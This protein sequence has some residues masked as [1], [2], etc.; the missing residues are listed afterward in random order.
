MTGQYCFHPHSSAKSLRNE[1]VDVFCTY[2]DRNYWAQGLAMWRSLRRVEPRAIL[3]VLCLDDEVFEL[4]TDAAYPGLHAICLSDV[5][6]WEPDLLRVKSQRSRIEYYF[7]LSPILPSYVLE[8]DERAASVTYLDADLW[9]FTSP[10]ALFQELGDASVGVI[11]HRFAAELDEKNKFGK[12]NV[13]WVTFRRDSR[14]NAV[15]GDWR[16]RCLEWCFD[17]SEDGRFADQGYLN[18]WP[19][20]FGGVKVLE[21]PG[22]NVAPWN[23]GRYMLGDKSGSPTVDG[24]PVIFFHF[25]GL[26]RTGR[27]VWWPRLRA[28]HVRTTAMVYRLLSQP[29]LR[30]LGW[31]ADH[32]EQREGRGRTNRSSEFPVGGGAHGRSKLGPRNLLRDW[33]GLATGRAM[34]SSFHVSSLFK[35]SN[36]VRGA[37][38]VVRGAR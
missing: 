10:K 27:G 18:D 33:L 32:R 31:E 14:A 30:A 29:Y 21:N 38:D 11:A 4:V 1:A 36:R 13:G 26:R 22:G 5:E 17:W 20:R 28:Y 8:R 37:G 12:Y 35:G 19:E 9:F 6:A 7:T 16:V 15:L 34:T 25:H 24:R 3:W 23:L 2:F